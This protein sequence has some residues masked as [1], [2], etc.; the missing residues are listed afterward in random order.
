MTICDMNL[1][2]LQIVTAEEWKASRAQLLEE[3]KAATR[4]LSDLAAK[5]RQLPMVKVENPNDIVFAGPGGDDKSLLELFEN[6]RQLILYDF[7][8]NDEDKEP[9]VGCS[10][11]MD[12]V[13]LLS[14]LGSR[15]TAFVAA[16]PASID[17]I[18]ALK[19]RMEWKFPFYSSKDTYARAEARKQELT[20]R[21]TNPPFGI[22][23]FLR[24]DQDVFHTYSTT[25][26]GVEIMLSTYALLDMTPLGRQEVGNGIGQ[27]RLHDQ[28]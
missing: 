22:A 15:D 20:W 26:R 23:V 27:F 3:E 28:Y 11:V 16:A 12:H 9:C 4:L 24:Q 19:E 10:F 2:A 14:H 13:P 21:P 5:R 6:R 25:L 7:M 18:S 8:L 17:Q 1:I